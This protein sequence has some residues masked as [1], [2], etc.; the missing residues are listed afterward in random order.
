MNHL[1]RVAQTNAWRGR[2]LI[3]KAGLAL[4]MLLLTLVLPPWPA[5]LLVAAV[6]SAATLWGAR[7]PVG[8]WAGAM[9]AP[10]GFLLTGLLAVAWNDPVQ[11]AWLAVRA[12]AALTCLMFLALTCPVSHVLRGLQRCGLPAEVAEIAVLIYRL[13][14]L[15]AD[16]AAAMNAAQAARLG[17]CQRLRSLGLLLANL[18]P[19]AMARADAL[20]VGLL[21]RG[22]SGG[23]RVLSRPNPVSWP[24]LAAVLAA[25]ALVLLV[26]VMGA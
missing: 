11:A 15:L 25:E 19:R 1:D 3:E 8:L 2:S 12:M 18:L 14:F 7:V 26:G 13:L 5:A 17:Q 9:V 10:V 20:E 24:G 23:M 6:M 16:T 21:A 4:G 22:W